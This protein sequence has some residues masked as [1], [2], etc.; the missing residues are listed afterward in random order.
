VLAVFRNGIMSSYFSLCRNSCH[1]TLENWTMQSASSPF[2]PDFKIACSLPSH[3][4]RHT[5]TCWKVVS[6]S[7]RLAVIAR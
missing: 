2:S 4:L 3:R 6:E 5:L 7:G 1:R